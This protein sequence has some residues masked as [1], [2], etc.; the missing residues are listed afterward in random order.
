M[1]SPRAN[2]TSGTNTQPFWTQGSH[3]DMQANLNSASKRLL[4]R[5][6]AAIARWVNTVAP[7]GDQAGNEGVDW[8]RVLPFIGMHLACVGVIWVGFSWAAFW[9]ALA[10]YAVRMFALTGMARSGPQRPWM[11]ECDHKA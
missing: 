5:A 9:M 8:L 7:C 1:I 4:P 11:A 3:S 6:T 10:L 2:Q